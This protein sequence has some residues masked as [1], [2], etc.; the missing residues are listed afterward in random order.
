MTGHDR[1]PVVR[2]RRRGEDL[3]VLL[4][5][6]L[7]GLGG[8]TWL[9]GQLA[10]WLATGTWPSWHGVGAAVLGPLVAVFT[11]PTAPLRAWPG[12]PPGAVAVGLFWSVWA[13]LVGGVAAA[14]AALVRRM[15]GRGGRPGFASRRDVARRIGARAL[16]AQAARLR[17]GLAA[18]Q[19]RP[20]PEQLGTRLGRDVHTGVECYASIRQSKYIVGP[21]ESGKTSCVVIP[22]ALDHD[23]PL[24]AVS[25]RTDVIAATWRARIARGRVWLFDPLAAAPVLP[26][27]LWDPVRGCEDP[28]TAIRRAESM[29]A[30]VDMSGVSDGDVWRSRGRAIVRNLLHAAAVSG[31]DITT[32]LR[33]AYDQST[34]E[35]GTLLQQN[36]ASPVAWAEM[37]QQTIHTPDRQR[38]GY[39][40]AVEAA[41]EP[42]QHPAVL[43]VSRPGA[44]EQFDVAGFVASR[45]D[46]VFVL[47][48]RDQATSVTTLLGAFLD[49]IAHHARL[50]GVRA[51]HG[52]LD[53]PLRFLV[54]E[55]ANTAAWTALPQLIAEGAGRGVVVTV[56]VQ[57]QAQAVAS[58]GAENARSAWG[59]ASIRAVLPGVA[60][61]AE[62]QELAAYFGE[63]DEEIPSD[64]HQQG[65]RSRQYSL[66]QRQSMSTAD[67]RAIAPQHAII[68]AAGGLHPVLTRMQ[69]YHQRPD[70]AHTAAAEKAFWAALTDGRRLL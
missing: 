47:A 40:L 19:V 54:D 50:R 22:E 35:P 58:W 10:V 62:L 26:P 45:G 52:R 23:G 65:G 27:V 63:Y 61:M 29:T 57:D 36:P 30:S 44:A 53:P 28:T 68:I 15:R 56:I 8:L 60:G 67:V 31:G 69:P 38:A 17:P 11:D 49:E 41:M 34:V 59:S 24:V 14:V 70:A 7:L 55:A 39:Y 18:A 12:T 37:Q 6:A 20:Q 42:Y 25:S 4:L 21:S 66:R 2:H 48:E 3:G 5:L 33:W 32:V 51:V 9:A 16:L 1:R 46:T 43:D 13:L 64:T